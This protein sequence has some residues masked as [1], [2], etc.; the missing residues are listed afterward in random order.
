M[1]FLPLIP[2][3]LASNTVDL[4][5]LVR[6]LARQDQQSIVAVYPNLLKESSD[7]SLRNAYNTRQSEHEMDQIRSKL[8]FNANGSFPVVDKRVV[9]SVVGPIACSKLNDDAVIEDILTKTK[10]NVLIIGVQ[11]EKKIASSRTEFRV[12]SIGKQASP[13]EPNRKYQH[14][15]HYSLSDLGSEGRNFELRRWNGDQLVL[16]GFRDPEEDR[17]DLLG[18]GEVYERRQAARVR[19]DLPHPLSQGD[20]PYS[21]QIRVGGKPRNTERIG[22]DYYVALNAG[23]QPEIVIGNRTSKNVLVGLYVDGENTIEKV[24]QHP[25]QTPT[26][27][28]WNFKADYRGKVSGW[29]FRGDEKTDRDTIRPFIV[30]RDAVAT[31][32]RSADDPTGTIT[33]M[34]YS[35]GTKGLEIPPE[36]KIRGVNIEAGE[37]ES[38]EK[39]RS[40]GKKGLLLA[41]VT[42]YYRTSQEIQTLL[43]QHAE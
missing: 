38:I 8:V 31:D 22:N 24:Y 40:P 39:R 1:N 33:A 20:F 4:G 19:P 28:H 18:I 10:A 6:Y 3:V 7:G 35:S 13:T 12:H 14:Q 11:V 34:F 43:Q 27:G 21:V 15:R 16:T 25:L 2:L 17:S 5:E 37:P 29:R 9:V 36:I 41:A 32:Q 26:G 42:I 23:D 30:T